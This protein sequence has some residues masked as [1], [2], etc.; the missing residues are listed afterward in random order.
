MIVQM[1]KK[2][3]EETEEGITESCM[4]V[5]ETENDPSAKK[6]AGERSPES[7]VITIP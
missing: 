5:Q 6:V 4:K 3:P 2:R 1:E 7:K